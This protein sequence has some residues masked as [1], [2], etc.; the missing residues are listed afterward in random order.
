MEHGSITCSMATIGIRLSLQCATSR[1][2]SLERVSENYVG[3]HSGTDYY[4]WINLPLH[5]Q[6]SSCMCVQVQL[7]A[8]YV[9]ACV[10]LYLGV[11][12]YKYY[13]IDWS[14]RTVYVVT[15]ILNGIFSFL[16]I[17][18]ILGVT[19]G[20]SEFVFALGD[21]AFAG[22][23]SMRLHSPLYVPMFSNALDT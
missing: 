22:R 15:T 4:F 7:N 5:L 11:V 9:V 13:L 10:L 3:I 1:K 12:I 2:R 21:D 20:L 14:W 23:R 17:L 16:Q 19:F 18:L 8:I 6:F